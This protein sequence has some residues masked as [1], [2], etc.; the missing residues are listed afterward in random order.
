MGI[1]QFYDRSK[2][3]KSDL[4][5]LNRSIVAAFLDLLELLIKYALGLGQ[6]VSSATRFQKP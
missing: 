4:K 3:W 1:T 6:S 5:K 2:D